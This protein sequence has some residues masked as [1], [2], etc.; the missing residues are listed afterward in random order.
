M[1]DIFKSLLS[2]ILFFAIFRDS[3]LSKE[4]AAAVALAAHFHLNYRS[5]RNKF[6]LD[7]SAAVFFILFTINIFIL[8]FS[9]I[10]NNGY[11]ISSVVLAGM[12]WISLL[13]K[14]P[15]TLQYARQSVSAEIASS[16]IFLFINYILTSLWAILFTFMLAPIILHFSMINSIVLN[17]ILL[18]I[19]VGITHVFPKWFADRLIEKHFD[20]DIK[21]LFH[22]KHTSPI[23]HTNFHAEKLS[24]QPDIVTDVI[25]VGAGPIGLASALQLQ[26]FGVQTIIL[27]KHP[28]VSIHPKARAISARSM[29][30]FRRLGLEEKILQYNLPKSQNWFGWFSTLSGKLYARITKKTDYSAISPCGE[31]N[32]AQSYLEKELLSAYLTR[33]GK[34][35]FEHQVFAL[36][37]NEHSVQIQALDKKN[38]KE[39]IFQGSYLLAVDGAHGSIRQL[40]NIPMIGPDQINTVFSVFCEVDMDKILVDGKFSLAFILWSGKP[41]PIVLSIDGKHKWIFIF[42]S[43]GASVEALKNIYTNEYIKS[44]INEIIGCDLPIYII[45]KNAWSLG[46]QIANQFSAGK[47]FF[48]GDSLHRL[49]PTGGMGMNTGLQ[50]VNNLMWKLALVIRHQVNPTILNTYFDERLSPILEVMQWSIGNLKRIV[51]VQKEIAKIGIA[52]ID[53]Q[54]HVQEQDAHLNKSGLDLGVIYVSNI[55]QTT[56][57]TKPLMPTDQYIPNTYP[58]ARLPH[59]EIMHDGKMISSLDLIATEFLFLHSIIENNIIS[60]LDFKSISTKII[61]IVNLEIHLHLNNDEALWVRPDGHIAWKGCINQTSDMDELEKLIALIKRGEM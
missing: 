18:M 13:I 61:T 16:R 4:I 27:E 60:T 41:A 6:V 24:A 34:V 52:N 38:K 47:T 1:K 10:T 37:Q 21:E 43:E 58:G 2:W 55:V 54:A 19:G 8:K 28:S 22:E 40:L 33:G 36:A 46:A 49:P 48:V 53:F 26:Q 44:K 9:V 15:F 35:F 30:L 32:V 23:D 39:L 45:S 57:E 20:I 42:P 51:R 56:A 7:V 14:K 50:D 17:V 31:A 59:F 5:I 29:E 25:I 12:A 11:L 3:L